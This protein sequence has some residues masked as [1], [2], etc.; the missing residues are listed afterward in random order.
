MKWLCGLKVGDCRYRWVFLAGRILII[1]KNDTVL[2]FA[3]DY[4]LLPLE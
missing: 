4:P 3:G 2:Q 1:K